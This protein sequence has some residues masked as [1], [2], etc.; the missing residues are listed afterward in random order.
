[1]IVLTVLSTNVVASQR[2]LQMFDSFSLDKQKLKSRDTKGS[3]LG[4]TWFTQPERPAPYR[5]S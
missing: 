4:L 5:I 3:S 2:C 1:M